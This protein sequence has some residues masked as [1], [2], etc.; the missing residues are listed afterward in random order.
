M[1]TYQ[2]LC[3]LVPSRDDPS[4]LEPVIV[5]ELPALSTTIEA[6]GSHPDIPLGR[7][8]V[9]ATGVTDNMNRVIRAIPNVSQFL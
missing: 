3:P 9:T 6:Y 5:F 1:A 8:R 2:Y 7:C 4:A